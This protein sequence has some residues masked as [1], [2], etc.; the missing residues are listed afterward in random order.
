MKT[1][2]QTSFLRTLFAVFSRRAHV[3]ALALCCLFTGCAAISN[4]VANGIPVRRLPPEL[5][6]ESKAGEETISLAHLRQKPPA[7]YILGP[8]DILG[9]WIE[10]VLGEKG[11]QPPIYGQEALRNQ[12]GMGFPVPVRKDGTISVPIV[13]PIAVQGLTLEGVEA[14]LRKA[15]TEDKQVIRAGQERILVTLLQRR[16]YHVLV[17]RQDSPTSTSGDTAGFTG[18]S[19][20]FSVNFGSGGTGSR[21]GSGFALDLPAYENDVLNALAKTGGFP[22]TDAA[23][24]IIIEKALPPGAAKDN[25]SADGS[26]PVARIVR[27]PLRI[28][29]GETPPILPEDI[30]LDDGDTV[31]IEGRDQ[32]VF[33]TGGILPPGQYPLPRDMDLD[34]IEAI[35]RVGGVLNSGGSNSLNVGGQTVAQG[36]GSPSPCLATVL[37]RTPGGGQVAIRVDLNRALRDPTERIL[38]Q[39]KDFILLQERPQDAV[40]RYIGQTLRLSFVWQ[41]IVSPKFTGTTAASGP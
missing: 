20:G 14:A 40:A 22:G 27:I 19:V 16:T 6:G 13:A 11:Q 15:Y 17:I 36:L 35:V 24:E 10:G 25:P 8:G 41:T 7:D 38:I 5:L 2:A 23:N 21:R 39:P 9:V 33:F 28:R 26:I 31:L 18:R 30:V 29:R 32:E 34:I 1:P 3:L 37:R 12:P 4:P